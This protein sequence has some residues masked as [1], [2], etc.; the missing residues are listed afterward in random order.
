MF[1]ESP[2]RRLLVITD[3]EFFAEVIGTYMKRDR[4]LIE[5]VSSAEA[6]GREIAAGADGVLVDLAKRAISGDAIMTL[7]GR[8]QR[9]KIPMIILSAQP[10]RQLTEFA[11][12]VCATDVVSKTE[13]MTAIAARIRMVMRTPIRPHDDARPV[14]ALEWALV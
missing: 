11:A 8:A 2:E 4:I 5:R 7:A 1:N 10:R 6:A 13:T 3:D 9:S 14:E 12:V